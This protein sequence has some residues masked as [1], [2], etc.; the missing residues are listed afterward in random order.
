MGKEGVVAETIVEL[1]MRRIITWDILKHALSPYVE[2]LE[3]MRIDIPQADV[4]FHSLLSRLLM[5]SGSVFEPAIL[6]VLPLQGDNRGGCQFV[7]G[8]LI[9]SL[10]KVRNASGQDGVRRAIDIGELA[11]ALCTA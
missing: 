3:D 10:R 8:L 6:E 4:F 1:L 7:W 9:G 2:G 11:S 5:M